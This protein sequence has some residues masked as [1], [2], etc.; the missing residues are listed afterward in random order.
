MPSKS[1]QSPL[2][3]ISRL[4]LSGLSG[5]FALSL[6]GASLP[7]QASPFLERQSVHSFPPLNATELKEIDQL[8]S[9]TLDHEQWV[10][11]ALGL[12]ENGQITY[13][14]G[15]G[16]ADRE[17]KTAVTPQTHFRWASLSKPVTAVL[18]AQLVEQ[19]KLDLD[20]DIRA[21]WPDYHNA[22]GWPVS[23]RQLLGHLAG[24]GHYDEVSGWR[25][26]LQKYR[27]Q[28]DSAHEVDQLQAA[29]DLFAFAPLL[30]RPGTA[31]HYSSFG[32]ILAGAIV[33]QAGGQSYLQQFNQRIRQPLKLTSMQPDLNGVEI[34]Y[35]VSGYY[36]QG[37]QIQ[38]RGDDDV[39]WKLAGGGFTSNI[40][41]LA[42]F[43]QA[44]INHE[45]LSP[46]SEQQLWSSQQTVTGTATG[47]GLGFAISKLHGQRRIG[48][49]GAQS[50]TRTSLSFLPERKIGVVLMC[51]SEWANLSP[52]QDRIYEVLLNGREPWN[53]PTD[54]P[55]AS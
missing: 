19:G 23:Q 4:S 21:Y 3:F 53:L 33:A 8:V 41:D 43:T 35:R 54:L 47:Y 11:L 37:T 1:Y 44:L 39:A 36:R 18:S 15:Y 32:Y 6:S 48:H 14:K 55:T 24:I 49:L 28:V 26:G 16:W 20:R 38:K 27:Q 30:S 50:K 42:R 22:Q 51:N 29:A 31:Y 12:I 13:L 9:E 5:L 7:A 10:G 52:L 17:S 34:P 45:L 46:Q 40:G 25:E 2:K